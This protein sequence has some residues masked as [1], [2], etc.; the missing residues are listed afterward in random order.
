MISGVSS[1][2]YYY[3]A[4]S[5]KSSSTDTSFQQALLTSLDADED[6]K[7]SSDELQ[8]ALASAQ[9]SDDPGKAGVLVSLSQSFGDLDSDSDEALDLDELA[10]L[11]P[12]PP[13]AS[14]NPSEQAED[15][16][17][18]LDSDED[19]VLSSDELSAAMDSDSDG[20]QL[21]TALDSDG[22]GVVDTDEMTAA[23]TPPPPPQEWTSS[24]AG[25]ATQNA[26]SASSDSTETLDRMIATL[27]RQ[28]GL[29][30]GSSLGSTL[31]T[32]A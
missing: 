28:Y 8:S 21:F 2:S 12:S 1:S 32:A 29:D 9:T 26:G 22:D 11:K 16:I 3:T 14:M 23:L 19:G 10:T 5:R 24:E 25:D 13:P 20:S 15:L 4:N 30:S 31:S 27:A 18:S 6:G 17:S 7:V